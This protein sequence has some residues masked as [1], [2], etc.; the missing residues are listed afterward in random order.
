MNEA[1][2]QSAT[3]PGPMLE[4]LRTSAIASER[5]LHLLAAG[6]CRLVP[7]LHARADCRDVLHVLEQAADGLATPDHWQAAR[8]AV[9]RAQSQDPWAAQLL[10]EA[11][12]PNG[13]RAASG[14]QSSL[15]MDE[16]PEDLLRR[17]A[18][19]L[20]DLFGT[21]LFRPP[22]VL[23]PG[24]LAWNDHCPVRL[25]AACYDQ[26]GLPAGMLDPDRLALL[27]DALE[28]AGCT[29]PDLLAHLRQPQ[30]HWRGC[31][32]LDLILSK[33]R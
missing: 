27:P 26:P 29:D 28:E 23:A 1:Q 24:L 30:P 7:Q 21:L 25:A 19:L 18:D 6:F 20:R 17:Q 13:W 11:A 4:A 22:P 32:V 31:W 9:R 33:D 8:W 3:N 5:K 14:V 12:E 15:E 10:L 2:W 16:L